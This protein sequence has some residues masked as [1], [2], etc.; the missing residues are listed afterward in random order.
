[1]T[2]DAA[3]STQEPRK[4][5]TLKDVSDAAGVS[6]ITV[7]RA[8]RQP[9]SVLPATRQRVMDAIKSTGYV[10][11]LMARSLVSSRSNIVGLVVPTVGGSSLF[12]DLAEQLAKE[13]QEHSKQLLLGVYNWSES[14]E[15]EIVTAF[16]GRQV[17]ALV[18]TGFSHSASLHERVRRFDGPIVEIGS[19]RTAPI[20]MAVG[21][22]NFAAA[23]DMT[24]HLLKRDYRRI[25]VVHGSTTHNDQALERYDGYC[26][27][28]KDAGRKVS[29]QLTV[30][31]PTPTTIEQG[32]TAMFSLLDLAQPPDAAFFQTDN[33]AHGAMMACLSRGVSVPGDVAI[34]GFGDLS[35]SALLPVP[36][37][38]V[39]ARIDALGREAAKVL[40]A[41]FAGQQSSSIIHDVG[42]ELLIRAST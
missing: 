26:A 34:A 31:V 10:P 40:L 4:P 29:H 19:I 13:L 7:S 18:L 42:Y 8:L 9:E 35:M 23:Y 5:I 33:L 41:R 27:A 37:T 28:M 22:D 38:T 6:L 24:T 20:D 14:K 1:M 12:A 36:L 30:A 21:Y 11:N 16:L 39:K 3:E 32:R 2:V 15:Y 25:A 17:D